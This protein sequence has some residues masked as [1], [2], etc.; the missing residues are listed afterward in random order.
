MEQVPNI[1]REAKLSNAELSIDTLVDPQDYFMKISYWSDWYDFLG[2]TT[3]HYYETKEKWKQVVNDLKVTTESEYNMV[4][5]K[6]PRLPPDPAEY[7]NV[8]RKY[9]FTNFEREVGVRQRRKK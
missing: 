8:V 2:I 3:F 1:I 4:L 7:Y 9:E 6:D 5:E